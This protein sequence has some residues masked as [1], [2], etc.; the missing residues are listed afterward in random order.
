VC[1]VGYRLG[2]CV[3]H[4]HEPTELKVKAS[5]MKM[6]AEIYAQYDYSGSDD[7]TLGYTAHTAT[8]HQKDVR[9]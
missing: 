2:A 3:V 8:S 4:T 1:T 5:G 7:M 9:A 6:I